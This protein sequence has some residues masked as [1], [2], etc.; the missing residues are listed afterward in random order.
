MSE[1]DKRLAQ[2]LSEELAR[3]KSIYVPVK[4]SLLRR[5]LVRKVRCKK[6]H[7][8]PNDEFCLPEVGPNYAIISKY[9]QQFLSPKTVG[10]TGGIKYSED[11][12]ALTIERI[13]PDGY[14]ILNGHHR[15]AAAILYHLRSVPIEIVDL[16]SEAEVRKMYRGAKHDRL[17]AFDLDEVVFSSSEDPD[18]LEKPLRFPLNRIYRQRLRLGIPALFHF[19]RN[20]GYDIWVYSS[21]YYSTEYI[22]DLF[23]HY[24]V[25]LTGIVTGTERKKLD[26]AQKKEQLRQEFRDVYTVIL[27]ADKNTLLRVNSRTHAYEEFPLPEGE[28]WSGEI[29]KIILAISQQEKTDGEPPVT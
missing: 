7:P 29:M 17:V 13:R 2:L 19:L 4:S 3:Y 28:H 9:E 8:N 26:S 6:L 25:Q 24:H 23:R 11:D 1:S 10:Y 18:A 22:R 12:E 16:P 21:N 14:M 5:A 20:K 27:H 15:W